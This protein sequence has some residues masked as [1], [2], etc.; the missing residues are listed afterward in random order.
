MPDAFTKRKQGVLCERRS[1]P[2]R[3]P[4]CFTVNSDSECPLSRTDLNAEKPICNLDNRN[5]LIRSRASIVLD[6]IIRSILP[7]HM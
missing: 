4:D 1:V 2:P 7:T 3:D 5:L 6:L